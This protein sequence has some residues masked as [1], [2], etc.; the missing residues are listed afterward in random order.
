MVHQQLQIILDDQENGL[1]DDS[2][3]EFGRNKQFEDFVTKTGDEF[4]RKNYRVR[5]QSSL[6]DDNEKQAKA[7]SIHSAKDGYNHEE[8]DERKFNRDQQIEINIA[9]KD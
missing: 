3:D 4:E 8:E 2:D 7:S 6:F 5:P 9:R 1:N